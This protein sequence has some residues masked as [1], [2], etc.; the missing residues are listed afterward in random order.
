M[1]GCSAG[2]VPLQPS[3]RWSSWNRERRD[4]PRTYRLHLP[5]P[6]HPLLRRA[7]AVLGGLLTA[8][9]VSW[10][11][12]IPSYLGVAFYTEQ[13]LSL[14][15]GFALATVY[16][17]VSWSGH[18]HRGTFPWL[19]IAL[20]TIALA[21]CAWFSVEYQRLLNDVPY[22]TLEI[23]GLSVLLVPLVLEAMRRCRDGHS[24]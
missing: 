15:L 14:V 11:L 23:V 17:T 6:A 21:A 19:D 4:S 2:A 20:G 13:L 5:E 22:Y 7:A 3:I 1:R 12:D 8:T 9:C 24:C 10:A 18:A 16:Y